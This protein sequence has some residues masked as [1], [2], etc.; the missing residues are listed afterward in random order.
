MFPA[1]IAFDSAGNLYIADVQGR[2]REVVNST[3]IITTIAGTGSL[4]PASGILNTGY[5]GDGGAATDAELNNPLS[6]AL[7]AAGNVY[8]GDYGNYRIR[9]VSTDGIITTIGGNGVQG[10]SGDGGPALD[11]EFL[12]PY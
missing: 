4:F 1:G 3:G 12:G 11:A 10:H 8:I 2:I 7:D 5:S 9:K 6:V